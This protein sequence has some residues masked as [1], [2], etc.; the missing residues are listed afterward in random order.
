MFYKKRKKG[1]KYQHWDKMSRVVLS[2][3]IHIKHQPFCDK[4]SPQNQKAKSLCKTIFLNRFGAPGQIHDWDIVGWSGGWYIV[5]QSQA[6]PQKREWKTVVT[7]LLLIVGKALQNERGTPKGSV[8]ALFL[9]LWDFFPLFPTIK[10]MKVDL[11]R[12]NRGFYILT[13]RG[14]RKG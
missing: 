1:R 12:K 3:E 11:F 2:W 9:A 6:G 8:H 4:S 7:K 5:I 10:D 13:W 14:R